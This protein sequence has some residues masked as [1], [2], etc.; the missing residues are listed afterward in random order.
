[1]ELEKPR[2]SKTSSS[3]YRHSR[4]R[5][6]HREHGDYKEDYEFDFNDISRAS[7]PTSTFSSKSEGRK[8]DK[9]HKYSVDDYRRKIARL[10]SE[11]DLERA[12]SKKAHK[13]KSSELRELRE[14]YEVRKQTE[15][16]DLETK[17]MKRLDKEK[18]Q[19]EE[20]LRNTIMEEKDKELQ[21]VLKYKEDEVKELKKR[22]KQEKESAIK[23]ALENEKLVIAEKDRKMQTEME[24]LKQEKISLEEEYKKKVA[25]EA[26]KEKEFAKVKEE[27]DSELRRI[28]GESKKLALGNLEKLKKAEK[29]LNDNCGE[30]DDELNEM[31]FN[32]L[33]ADLHTIQSQT[34]SRAVSRS[35]STTSE[36]KFDE[37]N[38]HINNLLA[39]PA[40]TPAPQGQSITPGPHSQS[41]TPGPHSQSVTPGPH[42]Q[43]VTPG[44]HLFAQDGI[45]PL[46]VKGINADGKTRSSS[47]MSEPARDV[48]P[49]IS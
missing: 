49:G 44:P 18:K 40:V 4:E 2:R 46:T 22:Y 11:L 35:V 24:K 37:L 19:L 23:L 42:G 48:L 33:M 13:E 28:L 32:E 29:A 21:D 8:K 47:A 7:T 45:S 34:S 1:M 36:L 27:Y 14:S 20:N 26:K 38:V 31:E 12:K 10:K 5:R 15:I 43:S 6:E 9:E 25:D 17:M 16:D 41:V 3:G 30:S 39:S